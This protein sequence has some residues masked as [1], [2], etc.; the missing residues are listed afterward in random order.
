M[1]SLGI[2]DTTHRLFGFDSKKRSYDRDVLVVRTQNDVETMTAQ[3]VYIHFIQCALRYVTTLGGD[4]EVHS[5]FKNSYSVQS[6]RINELMYCFEQSGLGTREDSLQCIVPVLRDQDLLPELAA[7]S[8]N[9]RRQT[10]RLIEQNNWKSA[11]AMTK[12]ICERS[13]GGELEH[14][15]YELGYLCRRALLSKDRSA[16]EQGLE[17]IRKILKSTP[18]ADFLQSQSMRQP[19]RWEESPEYARWWHA[20]SQ[21]M[22]WVAWHISV[23]VPSMRWAQADLRSLNVPEALN[24][25]TEM[26]Q[27]AEDS[28]Q[29]IRALEEWL[30]LDHIDFSRQLSGIEDDLGFKWAWQGRFYT[31]LY[32]FMMRLAK[33]GA[34]C[35][36]LIQHAYV[37]AA[38]NHS[39]WAVQVLQS[40]DADINTLSANNV[41][42]LVEVAVSEDLF[43]VKTLLANG[44]DP[45]GNEKA[46]DRRPLILAAHLGFTEIVQLLLEN[47]AIHELTDSIGLTALQWASREDRL[48]TVRLLLSHGAEI[49]QI[50]SDH[51]TPLHSAVVSDQYHMVALLLENG[52]NINAIEASFWLTALMMAAR[53]SFADV[54]NLLLAKG[55][56]VYARDVEGQTAL[57]WARRNGCEQ[58]T[59]I[60]ERVMRPS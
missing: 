34:K 35:P 9:I 23:N 14:S 48:D 12:W 41:S 36:T 59:A 45:N 22:G 18:R 24:L 55:A 51:L 50:G 60:L 1:E 11:L 47:G 17:Y 26:D 31:L 29:G 38:K 33:V 28:E 19:S 4:V 49:D 6:S 44:A 10:E 16:Q 43:A 52:A 5:D 37:I 13:E 32:F 40:H 8:I 58:T 15:A 42:A 2:I 7:D 3:D 30:T 54:L 46:P 27:S 56:D 20:F 25:P 39:P 21:Q 57:D 53:S